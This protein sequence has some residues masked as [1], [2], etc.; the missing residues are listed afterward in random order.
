M[1]RQTKSVQE[2]RKNKF[3]NSALS[4][5]EIIRLIPIKKDNLVDKV[6]PL[7]SVFFYSKEIRQ[8]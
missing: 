4:Q 1:F 6:A 3:C 7:V 5:N 2:N 8:L